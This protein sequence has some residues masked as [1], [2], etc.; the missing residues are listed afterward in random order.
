MLCHSSRA[1]AAFCFQINLNIENDTKTIMRAANILSHFRAI[2]PFS[3]L[4]GLVCFVPFSPGPT[5]LILKMKTIK[6]QKT[7]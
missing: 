1:D 6:K 5:R 7:D 3:N 2:T 4:S